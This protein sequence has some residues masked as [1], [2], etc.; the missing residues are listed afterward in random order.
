MSSSQVKN[1]DSFRKSGIKNIAIS[2]VVA[3]LSFYSLTLIAK[4]F[5]GSEGSDAYFFLFSLTTLATG[6]LSSIFSTVFLPVFVE[7]KIREGITEAS[8][9]AGSILTWCILII[10]PLGIAVYVNYEGFYSLVSKFSH[11]QIINVKFVLI[12]F[13]PIFVISVLS[14][15]FRTIVLALGHYTLAAIGAVFQPVFLIFSLFLL[16]SQ[17]KEETLALS[18]LLAKL[19]VLVF[20]FVVVIIKEKLKIPLQIKRNAATSRFLKI[21]A[22]YWA[23]DLISNLASFFFSYM[24]T[25]L[26]A[27]ILTSISYAQ[28]VF[29]LPTTL[30]FNPILEIARTKFSESQARKDTV[31]FTRHYNKLLQLVLYLTIP[32]AILYFFI[33]EII[34]SSLFQRGAFGEKSVNIA[35]SCLRIFAFS[36][37]FT[38]LF[39]VNGRACESFQRLAWPSFFGTLG[40]LLLIGATF[41]FVEKMG[42]L[43]IPYARITMDSLYF[44]PFGFVALHLFAGKLDLSHFWKVGITALVASLLPITAYFNSGLS[45]RL[46]PLFPSLWLLGIII[47]CF[48]VSYATLVLLIDHRIYSSVKKQWKTTF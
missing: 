6:M 47:F 4:K 10:V 2:G 36:I 44:L 41:I 22:P 21:S 20:M 30:I 26:G 33:P 18:L 42:Y 40:N 15:F 31:T 45:I 12:Y 24:A 7:L 34:I 35:A 1:R 28:R 16:S 5:G 3:V 14:E 8:E 19:A 11:A 46:E 29:T 17:L 9:F 39:M 38:C 13:A 43:G 25:G 48:S 37:P 23:A 32:I 27:G